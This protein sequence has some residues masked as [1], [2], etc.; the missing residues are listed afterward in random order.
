MSSGRWLLRAR[1]AAS[2]RRC[3]RQSASR[4][5]ADDAAGNADGDVP[6]RVACI[7]RRGAGACQWQPVAAAR[8]SNPPARAWLSQSRSRRT[9]RPRSPQRPATATARANRLDTPSMPTTSV[10]VSSSSSMRPKS[11]GTTSR[12]RNTKAVPGGQAG[13][14]KPKCD[15]EHPGNQAEDISHAGRQSAPWPAIIIASSA[16]RSVLR[17]RSDSLLS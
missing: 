11:A 2:V 8:A 17:M 4:C 6:G 12:A 13:C 1:S 10:T 15:G 14:E 16:S 3:G 5:G 7:C 9:R